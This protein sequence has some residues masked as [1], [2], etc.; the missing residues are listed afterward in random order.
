MPKR[1]LLLIVTILIPTLFCVPGCAS[2]ETKTADEDNLITCLEDYEGYDEIVSRSLKIAEILGE[3]WYGNGDVE[4]DSSD[5]SWIEDYSVSAH[6]QDGRG[7]V[8]IHIP[9]S[10]G[11]S[12]V[13][14]ILLTTEDYGRT[15]TPG[16][17]PYHI[18]GRVAQIAINDDF[19]Y[20]IIDSGVTCSSH[21]LVSED[22][23]CSFR[24]YGVEHIVPEA[25]RSRMS[26]LADVYMRIINVENDGKVVLQCGSYGSFYDFGSEDSEGS[27]EYE[28]DF[29]SDRERVVMILRSDARFSDFKTLYADDSIFG[30]GK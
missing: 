1:W 14:F 28:N 9:E 11:M 7:V 25:H 2:D 29:N 4:A 26:E 16:K 12:Q 18:A 30:E 17:G 10:A 13:D 8:A 27:Y 22:M 24:K 6:T 20:L 3:S 19:V 5:Y 21:I 23:G 15:W